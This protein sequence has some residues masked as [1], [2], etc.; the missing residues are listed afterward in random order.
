MK[1]SGN[2]FI[3]YFP[4]RVDGNALLQHAVTMTDGYGTVFFGLV[5]DRYAEGG[6]D[7]VHP[8]VTLADRVFFL[9]K[10]AKM[11]LARVHDL[12]GDFGQTVFFGEGQDG[13]LDRGQSGRES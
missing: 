3:N 6:S 13:Q 4:D 9:V 10:A 5:V 8:A 12:P 2:M 11:R 7:G 1:R